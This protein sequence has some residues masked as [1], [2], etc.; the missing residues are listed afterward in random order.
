MV[1]PIDSTQGRDTATTNNRYNRKGEQA[2]H[3]S[4][5]THSLGGVHSCRGKAVHENGGR[6]HALFVNC[7]LRENL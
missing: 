3:G 5:W 1:L 6:G 4:R 2:A 7:L